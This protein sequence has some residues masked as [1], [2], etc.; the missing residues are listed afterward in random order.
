MSET[1]IPS[2]NFSN[3]KV[4]RGYLREY[5]NAD[6][7]LELH[8][9]FN[10]STITRTR[11]VEITFGEGQATTRGRDFQNASEVLSSMQYE[12]E[13]VQEKLA[14]V[15]DAAKEY[16]NAIEKYNRIIEKLK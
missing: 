5:T 4:A 3:L 1:P 8:F 2:G 14:I 7:P 9:E 13:A 16:E 11:S 6:N 10:P 12:S 15:S